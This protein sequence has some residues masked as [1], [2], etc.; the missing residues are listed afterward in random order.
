MLYIITLITVFFIGFFWFRSD[1]KEKIKK[2]IQKKLAQATEYQRNGKLREYAE[3]IQEVEEL[4]N[5]QN[6]Q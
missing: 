6:G 2:Q 3:I 4:E 1:P 5:K